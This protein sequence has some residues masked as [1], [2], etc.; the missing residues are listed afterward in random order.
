MSLVGHLRELRRR[1]L[2]SLGGVLLASIVCL[3]FYDYLLTL[4][5]WPIQRGIGLYQQSHP[6]NEAVLVTQGVTSAFSFYVRICLTAG[7]VVSSPFWLFQLWRFISPGLRRGERK[8]GL[9]FLGVAIPLFLGGVVLGY[10]VC[11]RGF[12]LLLGFNPPGVLNLNELN[13]YLSLEL[14]VLLIFG[15]AFLLPVVLVGL[16]LLGVL[17]AASLKKYRGVAI[18]CCGVFAAVATPTTDPFTMIGLMCPMVAMLL[19]AEL[20]C[21]RHDRLAEIEV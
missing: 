21:R 4:V 1:F 17:P 12:A 11:P 5:L 7:V 10:L 6:G 19:V 9:G 18:I 15:A 14:R 8:L 3:F 16:N 2:F 13:Q 20:I